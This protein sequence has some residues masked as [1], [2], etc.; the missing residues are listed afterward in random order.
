[1]KNTGWL[2]AN[3][4]IGIIYSLK[5]TREITDGLQGFLKGQ[6]TRRKRALFLLLPLFMYS[7]P[8]NS[9]RGY[10]P[11]YPPGG[12]PPPVRGSSFNL[13]AS[14]SSSARSVSGSGSGYFSGCL[15]LSISFIT[16][17]ISLPSSNCFRSPSLKLKIKRSFRL[18]RGEGRSRR[19][20]L[21]NRVAFYSVFLA[22]S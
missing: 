19:L 14:S 17:A 10:P 11:P 20:H 6:G 1:M 3:M 18:L 16:L 9:I 21:K 2:D 8:Y 15:N 12:N 4:S 5:M 7:S 22:R 13:R